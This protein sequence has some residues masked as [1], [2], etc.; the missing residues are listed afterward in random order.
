MT[1]SF[2]TSE[3][4]FAPSRAIHVGLVALRNLVPVAGLVFFDW[5]G[6]AL[7]LV[8][9]VDTLLAIAASIVLVAVH[10]FVDAPELRVTGIARVWALIKLA[11]GSLI[12]AALLGV[13]LG[14]PV[15]ITFAESDFQLGAELRQLWPA[16]ALQ[17]CAV[18]VSTIWL[19]WQLNRQHNDQRVLT[20]HAAFIFARWLAVALASFIPILPMWPVI[21]PAFLV[22]VYAGGSIWF[23]L[24]PG[25]A[26]RMLN[27]KEWQREQQGH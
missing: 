13:P 2:D 25:R 18:V 16:I 11:L 7:L 8:Y 3:A 23:E 26:L 27:P 17:A 22:L 5:A 15:F 1:T 12:A 6:T 24:D 4:R 21:G 20:Y 19:H 10:G 9:F 14:V